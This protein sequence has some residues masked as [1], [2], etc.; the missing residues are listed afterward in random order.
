MAWLYGPM[1]WGAWSVD[2]FFFMDMS[3]LMVGCRWEDAGR[4]YGVPCVYRVDAFEG[5]HPI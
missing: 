4:H 5:R 1:A 3:P 2:I